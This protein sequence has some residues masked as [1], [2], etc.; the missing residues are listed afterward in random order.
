MSM[1]KIKNQSGRLVVLRLN[2]GKSLFLESGSLSGELAGEEVID[3]RMVNK[4]TERQLIT[5]LESVKKENH[6]AADRDVK[7]TK[8]TKK[9][10]RSSTGGK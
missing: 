3:N 1:F 5:V 8:K 9:N 7:E 2:S 10:K 4:L 6:S